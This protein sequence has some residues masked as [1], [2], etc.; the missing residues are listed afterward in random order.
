MKLT[1]AQKMMKKRIENAYRK[2]GGFQYQNPLWD[3]KLWS[4]TNDEI[5]EFFL[6]MFETTLDV[7]EYY[8]AI[9]YL[10]RTLPNQ[11]LLVEFHDSP[12]WLKVAQTYQYCAGTSN[13]LT[14]K[15][16]INRNQQKSVKRGKHLIEAV[17][18]VDTIQV[19]GDE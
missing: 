1:K 4:R 9:I 15:K 12:Q 17:K 11:E 19:I 10:W 8:V 14:R 18:L 13:D 7:V 16:T 3:K 6:K 5:R 2:K